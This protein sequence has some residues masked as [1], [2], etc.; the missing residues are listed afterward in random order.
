MSKFELTVTEP[1]HSTRCE[2]AKRMPMVS[3][4]SLGDRSVESRGSRASSSVNGES[5]ALAIAIEPTPHFVDIL[6][7]QLVSFV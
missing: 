3:A 2:S 6:K 5:D 4:V 7:F 1:I